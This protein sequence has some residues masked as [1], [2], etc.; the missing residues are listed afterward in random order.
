MKKYIY[1][2]IRDL[3]EDKD[4]TQH[5]VAEMLKE[6]NTTYVRWETGQTEIPVHILRELAKIYKTSMDYLTEIM[7]VKEVN[8]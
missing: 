8:K 7:E 2:R 6:H 3:R 1:Q 4:W 5:Q